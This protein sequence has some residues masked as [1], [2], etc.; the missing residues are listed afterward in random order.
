MNKNKFIAIIIILLALAVG[1]WYVLSNDNSNNNNQKETSVSEDIQS[2]QVIAKVN[3]EEVLG[4]QFNQLQSQIIAQQGLDISTL[5]SQTQEQLKQQV[6]E[7]IINQTLISQQIE[8]SNTVVT[9]EEI[10]QQLN[11]LKEQFATNE[12][13][14]NALEIQGLDENQLREN[15]SNNLLT[16]NYLNAELNFSELTA[17]QEEVESFY[18]QVAESNQNLPSLEQ[19]YEQV[20]QTLIQQKQQ[21]LISELI[22][23]LRNESNIEILI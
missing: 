10:D 11:S 15:I 18:Q 21:E 19:V 9:D 20:E 8:K 17:T 14:E 6:I 16:Q 4:E 5:D 13:F 12:E 1:A 2:D 22:N 7:S 3:N 23:K